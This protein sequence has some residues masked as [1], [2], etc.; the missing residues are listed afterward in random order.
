M[1]RVLPRWQWVSWSCSCSSASPAAACVCVYTTCYCLQGTVHNNW[2][3]NSLRPGYYC[4]MAFFFV[5]EWVISYFIFVWLLT[6]KNSITSLFYTVERKKNF[7]KDTLKTF[8]VLLFLLVGTTA[9]CNIVRATA[10]HKRRH[11]S[12]KIVLFLYFTS[13]NAQNLI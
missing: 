12:L 8:F 1:G 4:T 3:L 7:F 11:F 10:I 9:Y 6:H 13:R 2:Q 5:N